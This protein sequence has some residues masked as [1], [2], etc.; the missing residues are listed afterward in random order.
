M[1]GLAKQSTEALEGLQRELG[2]AHAQLEQ[3]CIFVKVGPLAARGIA[4][5]GSA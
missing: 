5:H 1:R 2:L 3:L 4:W